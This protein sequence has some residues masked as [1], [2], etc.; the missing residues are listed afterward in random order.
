[1]TAAHETVLLEQAVA[2]LVTDGSGTY[3]DGTFGRGGHSRLVLSRLAADGC[4]IGIDKDPQAIA[5]GRQ[6]AAKDQRFAIAQG[7][8]ADIKQIVAAQQAGSVNG[9]L[10]D[11]GCHRRSWIKLSADSVLCVMGRWICG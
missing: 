11:L 2:E 4:L 7:S 3:I 9:V 5:E 1:M 6:L 10:L 8:F